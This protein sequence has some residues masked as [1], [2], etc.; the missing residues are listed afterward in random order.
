MQQLI[1]VYLEFKKMNE[2]RS[3]RT[4]EVYRLALNRLVKFFGDRDPLEA[5][6]D[7]LVA[8]TGVWLHKQGLQDPVSRRTHVAAV[9]GFYKWLHRTRRISHDPSDVPYPQRTRKIPGTMTL[10]NAEKLMWAPD[11]STFEGVRD[12]AILSLLAGCGLRVTGLIRLNDDN[13]ANVEL[14]GEPRM[15]IKVREK[16]E[17]E[18]LLPIPKEADLLLRLYLE[19]PDLKEI[20]RTLADGNQV[21]FVSTMN[22]RVSPDK[23]HGEARRLTRGAVL[24]MIKKYGDA[25]GIPEEQLHPHAMRHLFGTEL[26][27]DAVD[28]IARQRLMGHEDPK[29]TAIYDHMAMRKLTR[30]ADRANPL[31]KMKTPVSDLIK[32]LKGANG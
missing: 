9:R 26:A 17:K 30:E 29:S 4:L 1:E 14:N 25:A 15:I 7:D 8:F 13:L 18:R 3:D 21:L 28:L 2:N 6:N 11:F 24:K 19:H 20:N 32:R 10:A 12:G 22:R 31:A 23:Y 16:G 5:S 27:E